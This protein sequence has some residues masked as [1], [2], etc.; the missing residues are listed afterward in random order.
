MSKY[1]LRDEYEAAKANAMTSPFVRWCLSNRI[2]SDWREAQFLAVDPYP[3][4]VKIRDRYR[5]E[6]GERL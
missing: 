2:T 4:A 1:A 3:G 5:A 6:T